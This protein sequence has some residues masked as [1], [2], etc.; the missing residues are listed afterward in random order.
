MLAR[1]V[2][3]FPA[4]GAVEL[5]ADGVDGAITLRGA[6]RRDL[7][8]DENGAPLVA[9]TYGLGATAAFE[10]EAMASFE[11][12]SATFSSTTV[13]VM[14]ISAREMRDCR[15]GNGFSRQS[16][17]RLAPG[18]YVE[19]VRQGREIEPVFSCKLD[20]AVVEFAESGRP[21]DND[22]TAAIVLHLREPRTNP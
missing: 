16:V 7:R 11:P 9:G 8:F 12:L 6:A 18:Q 2:A 21:V 19:A 22:G 10:L 1:A 14:N 13:R 20:A 17:G 3:E 15:F 5:R 4:F